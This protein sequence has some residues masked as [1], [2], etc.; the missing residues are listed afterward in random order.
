MKIR[1]MRKTDNP[2]VKKIIQ[3]S[4]ESL[5]LTIPGSAYFDPQL[6][7]LY[8]Y[9]Q[10]LSN[11]QYWVVEIAGQ[12]VG[13]VGIAPFNEKE[14]ICELQK[15]YLL[16]AYQGQGLAKDLM[17]TALFF[18]REFYDKC[19]L[20]TRHELRPACALYERYGFTRLEVPLVGSEHSAMDAWYLKELKG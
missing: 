6:G 17:A 10:Q 19:Y 15:L 12:V 4:L 8:E 7:E 13:G 2:V 9:Y 11:A 20:E 5:G 1:K 14:K 3:T 18:A 16:A